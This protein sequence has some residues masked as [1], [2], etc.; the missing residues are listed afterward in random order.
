MRAGQAGELFGKS[1]KAKIYVEGSLIFAEELAHLLDLLGSLCLFQFDHRNP[2]CVLR[3]GQDFA[4]RVQ[5]IR[6]V[7][8]EI[9]R[10]RAV[11]QFRVLHSH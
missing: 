9:V 4:E 6:P 2:K 7:L 3:F 10:C 5:P 8:L 1:L 11:R